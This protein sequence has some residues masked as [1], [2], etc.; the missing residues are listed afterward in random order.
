MELWRG[1]RDPRVAT[2]IVLATLVVVGFAF[3]ATGYRGVAAT[4]FVP[5]QV[6]LLVSGGIAGVALVGAG[7]ALL[8]VHLDR[9]E[10]A[11]ERHQLA[12]LQREALRLLALAPRARDGT[13]ET[14]QPA[15]R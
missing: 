5:F 13:D 3:L 2:T 12:G 1:L 15:S 6:P 9:T 7:V 8:N 10:A 14:R 11:Q 4:L